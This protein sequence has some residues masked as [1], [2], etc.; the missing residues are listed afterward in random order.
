LV[1]GPTVISG[2]KFAGLIEQP[3]PAQ[4]VRTNPLSVVALSIQVRSTCGPGC[5][6]AVKP[7]GDVGCA[8]TVSGT[9]TG[10]EAP[11]VVRVEYPAVAE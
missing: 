3:T 9:M 8:I 10:T 4:R 1:L 6:T 5:V 7:F 2:A 11:D